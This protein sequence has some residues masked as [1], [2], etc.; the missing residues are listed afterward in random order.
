MKRAEEIFLKMGCA[1]WPVLLYCRLSLKKREKQRGGQMMAFLKLQIMCN[2][3]KLREMHYN[4]E[5]VQ[6]FN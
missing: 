3:L 2:N 1:D 5:N 6:S 4:Q